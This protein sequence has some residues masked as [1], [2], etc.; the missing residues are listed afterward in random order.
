MLLPFDLQADR[1]GWTVIDLRTHKPVSF[2]ELPLV[3]LSVEDA[4]QAVNALNALEIGSL[5]AARQRVFD[6]LGVAW[7]YKNEAART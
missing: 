7:L 6:D 3:G 1:I 4:E 2:D 5:S